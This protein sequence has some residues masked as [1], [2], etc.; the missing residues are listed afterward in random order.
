LSV[1]LGNIWRFPYLVYTNGGGAFLVP[2]VIILTFIGRPM[3]YMELI[4]GQFCGFGVLRSFRGMPLSTGTIYLNI[5][6]N[7]S[8]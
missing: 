2:Y 6:Q 1:G 4:L 7:K 8:P 5:I 3:Y